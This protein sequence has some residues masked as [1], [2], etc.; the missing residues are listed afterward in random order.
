MSV[1]IQVVRTVGVGL[2]AAVKSPVVVCNRVR[3]VMVVYSLNVKFVVVVY[4]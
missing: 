4:H 2:G 3:V 1:Y